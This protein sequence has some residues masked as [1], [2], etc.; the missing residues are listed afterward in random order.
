MI[1]PIVASRQWAV[2]PMVLPIIGS[3]LDAVIPED[4]V[5]EEIISAV[6]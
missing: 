4:V 1:I 5:I 6:H 2:I 3:I